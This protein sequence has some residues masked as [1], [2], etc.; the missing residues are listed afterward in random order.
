MLK[1]PLFVSI[2]V[3]LFI[4]L[5]DYGYGCHR[6][7]EHGKSGPCGGGGEVGEF[8]VATTTGAVSYASG[9][10]PWLENSGGKSISM[11]HPIHTP[12]DTG[13]MT[14]LS[15]FTMPYPNG[16][17]SGLDGENCFGTLEIDF[18]TQDI[19]LFGGQIKKGRGGRAEGSFYFFAS[20][21]N[22]DP[23]DR[24]EVLYHIKVFGTFDQLNSTGWL[25]SGTTFLTMTDWEMH[26][27]NEG[28]TVK[29]ISCIGEGDFD[30]DNGLPN[31]MIIDVT[32][33]P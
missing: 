7:T 17:F 24:I 19:P 13:L 5:S 28:D 31:T 15:F 12:R 2:L 32:R 25:P 18:S 9:V 11:D 3:L 22:D 16:P 26:V 4:G 8:S 21:D 33:L 27:E 23:A 20:T 1:K 30:F 29:N 10:D 14:D 6:G